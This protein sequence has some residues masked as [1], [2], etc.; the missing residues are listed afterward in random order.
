MPNIWTHIIFVDTLCHDLGHK[1]LLDTSYASLH[2]GAQGPDPF[3]YHNFLP[4]LPD[5]KVAEV[6][7]QLHT[8]NC[9]PFLLDMIK[10]GSQSKHHLQAYI[11]GFVSHHILDRHTHPYIHYHAGYEGNKHQ[12]LEVIIDTLMLQ[13]ERNRKSWHT[14]VHKE[15]RI[16]KNTTAIADMMY[17]L[18]DTHYPGTVEA[19]S[20]SFVTRS[21]QHIQAAQ[22]VLYDPW[23]WK[24]KYFGPLVSSFS[25]QPISQP[26]DYLN[27][28]RTDWNHPATNKVRDESF[29]DLYKKALDEGERLFKHIFNYWETL[30]AAHWYKIQ[31]IIDNVSY[32]TGETLD[33]KLTNKYSR[34]II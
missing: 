20:P 14:P 2:M 13:R 9:G 33:K 8:E 24:N 12:K 29:L 3:F 15:I 18:I 16:K 17:T 19:Y 1:A 32:D 31:E 21:L 25:H 7:M 27:E 10:I 34:P 26:K 4:F 22:R 6:G 28:N 11:L 5:Q 23:K 30:E